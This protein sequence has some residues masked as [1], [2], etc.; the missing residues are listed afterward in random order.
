MSTIKRPV[1]LIIRDGWGLSDN[2]EGNAVLA[3][4]TPNIDAY[5]AKYPW[6]ELDCAGEAVGLPEGYQGSSEVGHLNMGAGRIVVQELKRID[7]GLR[8]GALFEIPKWRSLVE[9]W[10]RNRSR[11]H[12]LGLLQD[13][14]VHAHQEHLFKIMRR[15]RKEFPEGEVIIHP[16]MD[17]RDTPPRSSREYMAKL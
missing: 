13:E 9:D 6:T 12:L 1:A 4:N 5:K 7:D 17:G 11:L 8:T 15:A 3:A 16:F 2:V 14:G 10:R